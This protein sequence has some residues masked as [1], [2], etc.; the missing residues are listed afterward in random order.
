MTIKDSVFTCTAE[1]LKRCRETVDK[2]LNAQLAVL[3]IDI[4]DPSLTRKIDATTDE[5]WWLGHMILRV[6][7]MPEAHIWYMRPRE[8]AFLAARSPFRKIDEEMLRSGEELGEAD[9]CGKCGQ[10]FATHNDD[11][12]CVVDHNTI[13]G[14]FNKHAPP[15]MDLKEALSV[16]LELARFNVLEEEACAGSPELKDERDRQ[17]CAIDTVLKNFNVPVKDPPSN[18]KPKT[19]GYTVKDNRPIPAA[20]DECPVCNNGTIEDAG[21]EMRCR[22]ECGS[23][24]KKEDPRKTY[25]RFECGSEDRESVCMGPYEFV[26]ITYHELR[27]EKGET[28]ASMDSDARWFLYKEDATK[29]WWSDIVIYTA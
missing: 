11:G 1:Y 22:G 17:L 4:K 27:D 13:H 21:D 29:E 20:D 15:A 3:S 19:Y 10:R 9:F 26:Q 12:S 14:V 6:R 18:K 8:V 2:I 24:F 25:I 28:I 5:V 16:V 7:Y 23:I